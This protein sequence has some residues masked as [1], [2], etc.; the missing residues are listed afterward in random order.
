[1]FV[2]Q[3]YPDMYIVVQGIN[4]IGRETKECQDRDTSI[5]F[6]IST[7]KDRNSGIECDS[8]SDQL[9]NLVYPDRQTII[10]GCLTMDLV[11]DNEFGDI[12]PSTGKQIIER[13]IIFKHIITS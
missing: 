9:L 1:M 5:Q 7:R 10:P 8:I 4:S 2:Q 12:D 11:S 13:V 6:V 3:G